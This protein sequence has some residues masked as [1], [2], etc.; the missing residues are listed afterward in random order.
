MFLCTV[1]LHKYKK[2]FRNDV[3]NLLHNTYVRIKIYL[4]FYHGIVN[5][6]IEG[7]HIRNTN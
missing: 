5:I 2:T 7:H 3:H 1:V 6:A 4:A